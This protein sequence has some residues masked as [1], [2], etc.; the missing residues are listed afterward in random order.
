MPSLI[1][2]VSPTTSVGWS[3]LYLIVCRGDSFITS[4]MAGP[5]GDPQLSVQ[6]AVLPRIGWWRDHLKIG[7][8]GTH[9]DGQSLWE[10]RRF[11]SHPIDL[12]RIK[13]TQALGWYRRRL[14]I[15]LFPA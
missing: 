2:M 1:E 5:Y 8:T 3:M 12:F 14:C 10:C 11:R 7:Q 13:Q 4:I 15:P 6:T 9:Q